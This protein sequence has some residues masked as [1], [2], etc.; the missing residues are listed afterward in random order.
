MYNYLKL[1][2][3]LLLGLLVLSGCQNEPIA[4]ADDTSD[5]GGND[6]NNT[7][8]VN[9][10]E[11]IG[12]WEMTD[13]QSTTIATYTI[14][15]G[16]VSQEF[17]NEIVATHLSSDYV[18]TFTDDNQYT[19]NGIMEIEVSNYMNGNLVNQEIVDYEV[20][21]T[22]TWSLNGNLL[23]LNSEDGGAEAE[24]TTLDSQNFAYLYIG[25]LEDLEALPGYGGSNDSDSYPE[26]SEV[27]FEI[28][29]TFIK[30]E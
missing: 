28:E 11:L 27:N 12:D 24:I 7:G 26:G 19:S 15:Q 22:G 14:D 30:A 8:S 16:D 1:A 2:L 23:S 9:S 29:A 6:S 17:E 10:S 18:L 5:N 25:D 13:Y 21:Q 4:E 20:S 3:P